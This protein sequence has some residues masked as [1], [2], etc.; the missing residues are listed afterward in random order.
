MLM[1]EQ[2]LHMTGLGWGNSPGNRAGPRIQDCT[3][4]LITL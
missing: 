3:P 2:F 1:E 4:F